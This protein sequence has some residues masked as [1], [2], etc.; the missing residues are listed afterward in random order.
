MSDPVRI[1]GF[2]ANFD[3]EAV[4]R[5]LTAIRMRQVTLLEQKGADNQARKAAVNAVQTAMRAF[6]DRVKALAAPQSVSGMTAT[7]SGTAVAAAALPGAQPGSFTVSVSQLA[8]ATRLQGTPISAGLDATKPM[9][10]SN[11]GTAPTNG[12]FTIA[13]QFGGSQTFTVGPAAAQASVSLQSANID[14]AVTS[15]TFTV[16]TTGGGTAVISIDVTTDSL[17]DVV[18]QI[19]SAGVGLTAS[20]VNDANG[21]ANRLQLTS[22]SGDVIVGGVGDTSNFLSAMRLL[23]SAPGTTRTGEAFTKQMTLNDVIA[24]INASGIGVTASL[25]NDSYGRPNILTVTSTQGNISFGSGS[26][27]SNFLAVTGLLT[28]APGTTRSSANP[29][30]RLS[31]AAKL[32]DAGLNGG[33][34]NAG[35]QAIVINGVSISYNAATDS[36]TDVIARISASGA[37]VTARYDSLTDTVRLQNKATGDLMLTVE[38]APG[39]NLAAKLGLTTGTVTAGQNA[40]YSIDGGPVQESASNAVTF[41]GTTLTL[42][43]VTTAPVTVTV[44]QDTT[45]AANAIKAFVTEFNNVMKAIDAATKADGSKTNNQSGP[46]SGD[47]SLRQLKSDLRSIITSPG[48]NLQGGFTTL[49]QIG[50]TFG[51]IGSAVGTT[52]TLQFDE[53]K[54]AEAVRTN[55]AGVQE[56]LSRLSLSA[57][58]QPG[59]TG[60]LSGISGT[61]AGQEPG[62]WAITDDG[63][64]NLTAVFTPANGG[65]QI[66]SSGTIAPNG[67]NGNLIP[68]LTLTAGPTLQAGSHTITVGATAESVVQRLKRF[69]ENQAGIG[70]SL[71]KRK[72]T[73]DR[74][75]SDISERIATLEKRIEAEMEQLRRKFAAMEQ[76]QARAQSVLGSLQQLANQLAANNGQK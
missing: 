11:F 58:L 52:N 9:N 45:S 38:D 66:S 39:G 30:A 2:Y 71:D 16:G 25:A 46:L 4:I 14:M 70:G 73:Y 54:F 42:K 53:A 31:T 12:T 28:S 13:T 43:E 64:G 19:N 18:N 33:P 72:A 49:S 75:G 27:T 63:A 35:D 65:P 5:Q 6:L 57:T 74:I 8:T 1:G 47:S 24:D 37:G 40:Q 62:T 7:S 23:S 55:Q 3:T 36:L 20:I 41:S 69:A 67:S 26:D 21:R 56:L 50:L 59:G 61:Y 51:A 22:S 15:G 68:G 60:S 48:T 76:A 44:G 29:I 17:N 10:Q 32:Q 34:P